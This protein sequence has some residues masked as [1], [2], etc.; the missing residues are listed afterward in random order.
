MEKYF[1]FSSFSRF[2]E[3]VHGI[4]NRSYGDMRFG[5]ISDEEV[6]KNRRT[7]LNELGINL[8][9]VV[10]PALSHGVKINQVGLDDKGK[11]SDDPKTRLPGTDGLIT[12]ETGVY[13]MVTV[14]DC[15][16]I[17][18]YDP[19]LK[20]V[21][22][23]HAGWRGII[24]QIASHTIEKFKSLGSEPGNLIIGIG[25]GI[26]QKHFVVKKPVLDSFLDCYPQASFVR[27]QHGYVDLKTALK[28]DFKHLGISGSNM[29]IS[30]ICPAC[31][32]GLYG[33]YRKEGKGAPAQAAV[34]GIKK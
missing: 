15:L 28:K 16:P 4:S 20:I 10:N 1:T 9:D 11:G 17:L 29:E 21:S 3:I 2:Q 24:S 6:V 25:P 23:V 26:C 27:N 18:I 13:L 5:T 14:A 34:I 31:D 32:N 19:V 7:F 22:V 8:A 12:T 33:S 30:H